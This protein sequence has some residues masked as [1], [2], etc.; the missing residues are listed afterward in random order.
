VRNSN[1]ARVKAREEVQNLFY[2]YLNIEAH[3]RNDVKQSVGL[4]ITSDWVEQVG[5]GLIRLPVI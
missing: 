4:V 2:I 3:V 1:P 5:R